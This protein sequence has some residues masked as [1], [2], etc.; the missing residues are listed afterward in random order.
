M[1]SVVILSV[2]MLKVTYKPFVLIVVMLSVVRL[3]VILL[4]VM[5]PNRLELK[6]YFSTISLPVLPIKHKVE[7]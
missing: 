2:I 1:V 7:S 5:V 3:N 4:S 6:M